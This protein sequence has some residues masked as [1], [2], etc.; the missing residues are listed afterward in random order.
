MVASGPGVGVR[1]LYRQTN[2][3]FGHPPSAAILDC[4]ASVTQLVCRARRTRLQLV[5]VRARS[6]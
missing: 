3:L 5:R 4:H 6:P 2:I 1:M